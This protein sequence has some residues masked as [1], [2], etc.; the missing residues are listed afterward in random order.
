MLKSL[1]EFA[2]CVAAVLIVGCGGGGGDSNTKAQS[3]ISGTG[4]IGLAGGTVSAD[5]SAASVSFPANAYTSNTTVTVAVSTNAPSSDRMVAGTA[6]EFGPSGSLAQPATLSLKYSP[7][8]IPAGAL[9]SRL[10]IYTANNGTWIPVLGSVV[11][12]VNKTVSAPTNHF[13]TYAVLA[14]N[15]FAGIYSG[16]YTDIRDPNY[17]GTWSMT[18]DTAGRIIATATGGGTNGTG[19]VSFSGTSTVSLTGTGNSVTGNTVT[20][21]GT[22]TLQPDGRN[23]NANGQWSSTSGGRGQWS[24]TKSTDAAGG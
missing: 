9:E 16:R 21:A 23:V 22:F 12:T 11:D 4:N 10:A 7:A 17:S 8:N 19:R 14:D 3:F 24:G 15:Q 20:F 13:S 18:V 2:A 5:A 1:R 6:Y